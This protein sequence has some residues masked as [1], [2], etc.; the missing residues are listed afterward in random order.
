MVY[1]VS[2][3]RDLGIYCSPS[4][5]WQH[6]IGNA[7]TLAQR[8]GARLGF[9]HEL[10]ALPADQ[11]KAYLEQQLATMPISD[12]LAGVSTEDLADTFQNKAALT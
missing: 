9:E 10:Q 11:I 3:E 5:L 8:L 7:Q 4:N 6:G 2:C 12:F 1:R